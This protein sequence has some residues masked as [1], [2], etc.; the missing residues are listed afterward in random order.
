M[1]FIHY[2]I[3]LD[4]VKANTQYSICVSQHYTHDIISRDYLRIS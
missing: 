1:N 4:K 2:F 3:V